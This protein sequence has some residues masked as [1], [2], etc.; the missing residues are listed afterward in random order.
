MHLNQFYTDK[1]YADYIANNLSVLSPNSV[2][3]IGHGSGILLKSIKEKWCKINAIGV[4]IDNL[5]V[6]KSNEDGNILAFKMSGLNPYLPLF[7]E[8]NF[9]KIDLL[10]SNPPYFIKNYDKKTKKIINSVGMQNIF[11]EKTKKIPSEIVFLAQNLRLMNEL[12]ELA[13]ILPA[14][15]ISGEKWKNLRCF[16]LKNYKITKVVQLPLKIFKDTEARTFILFIKSKESNYS[17]VELSNMVNEITITIDQATDRLDYNFYINSKIQNKIRNYD[18]KVL[19]GKSTRKKLMGI[20][21]NFIHTSNIANN[22]EPLLLVNN[23]FVN[24]VNAIEGDILV[25]RVGTRC[26]GDANMVSKGS[27]PVT[28]CV[29]IIRGKNKNTQK[30]IWKLINSMKFKKYVKECSLGV[31][32]QYIT[33]KLIDQF[34]LGESV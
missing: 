12:S 4:D 31:C 34:L 7:I 33:Y 19:R 18:Y 15:I 14:G 9:G 8:E 27:I 28:D 21:N 26:L 24:E 5:N 6:K 11:S 29:I 10:I 22:S 30:N 17:T 32:S 23:P 2:L 25:S 3:D 1:I 20:T 13:I 16:I